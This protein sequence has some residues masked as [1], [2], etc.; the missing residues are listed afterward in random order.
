[1]KCRICCNETDNHIFDVREMM[2]GS[3]ELFR[4]YQCSH[5]QCL[6]IECIPNNISNYYPNNYY[7][8][9][10]SKIHLSLL[11]KFLIR[12]RNSYVV[13]GKNFFGKLLHTKFPGSKFDFLKSLKITKDT[14]IIDVG[15]GAGSLLYSL[16]EIGMENILGVDPYNEKDIEYENGLVIQ[17]KQISDID[18]KWDMVMFHDSF[19]HMPDPLAVLQYVSELLKPGGHCIIRIPTVTSYAWEHYG[20]N[21]VQIDAPRHFFLH[22]VKSMKILA[23]Q[24]GLELRDVVYDS[25]EFQF[26]GSEAYIKDIPLRDERAYSQFSK[27]EIS[28][29][30]NRAS[31]LNAAKQGDHAIFYL[32][33]L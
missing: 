20:V 17:K 11:K 2:F 21:W 14:S 13:L 9:D 12:A 18:G 5:C 28:H 30:I 31:E 32:N 4:Y 10:D 24:S 33:K 25:T 26:I 16:R 23:D 6:Q 19:E 8:Y 22:S 1:M 3:R 7:S 27:L 29:L 15:C